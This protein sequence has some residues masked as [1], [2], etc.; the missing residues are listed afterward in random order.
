VITVVSVLLYAVYLCGYFLVVRRTFIHF[1]KEDP[2]GGG[3]NMVVAA[4]I[5]LFWPLV[6][7]WLAL[8]ATI[9]RETPRQR[10]IRLHKEEESARFEAEKNGLPWPDVEVT[11]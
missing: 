1:D 2:M 3:M 9:F 4:F 10:A 8:Q 5:S 11:P 6:L 7:V